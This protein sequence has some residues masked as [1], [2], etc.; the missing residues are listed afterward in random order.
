MK[1]RLPLLLLLFFSFFTDC[2]KKPLPPPIPAVSYLPLS[3]GNWWEY[4]YYDSVT[5]DSVFIR[6]E[7]DD[8]ITVQGY[9]GFLYQSGFLHYDF[10]HVKSDTVILASSSDYS[11]RR[12]L[13]INKAGVEADWEFHSV[14]FQYEVR[15]HQEGKVFEVGLRNGETFS[16]CIRVS[17]RA[18]FPSGGSQELGG[19]FFA[20]DLGMVRFISRTLLEESPAPFELF[21][22]DLNQ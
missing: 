11:Q 13:F 19:Y 9:K 14:L 22:Y 3:T 21:R 12:I 10:I 7:V 4:V 20:R 16:D 15:A 1:F 2:Q 5:Q 8:T 6:E 18:H 17:T